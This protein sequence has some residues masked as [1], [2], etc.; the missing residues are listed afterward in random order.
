LGGKT[1]GVSHDVPPI[2][3]PHRWNL[4]LGAVHHGCEAWA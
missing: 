2:L 1:C 4:I 3:M